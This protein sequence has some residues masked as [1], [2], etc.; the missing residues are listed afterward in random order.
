MGN[1]EHLAILRLGVTTWNRWRWA[2]P[3][4]RPDLSY[5]DLREAD[6]QEVDLG[7]VV[8]ADVDLS[9]A[10]LTNANLREADLSLAKL[11]GAKLRQAVF[12]GADLNSVDLRQTDLTGVDLCGAKLH[13]VN[14]C[15]ANLTG[16]RLVGADLRGA[17]CRQADLRQVDL[18]GADLC[19]TEL[20]DANLTGVR[21]VGAELRYTLLKGADLTAAQL[22]ETLIVDVDLSEVQG[23]AAVVHVGRSRLDHR[24]LV[25]SVGI[26]PEFLRG[27][28]IPERLIEC[29]VALH[30]AGL[31]LGDDTVSACRC[32]ET[33][34]LHDLDATEYSSEHL[35]DLCQAFDGERFEALFQCPDTG[36]L[37]S[38]RE[39]YDDSDERPPELVQIL[40]QISADEAAKKFDW[41]P[42]AAQ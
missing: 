5:A 36:R 25:R 32:E 18:F 29:L 6:L 14:L 17:L 42:E 11:A 16:T 28:G 23:L 13:G 7:G 39:Y 37:W 35:H 33:Q 12:G 20:P 8:L 24:T 21:L 40:I 19:G 26:Q 34:E 15:E 22:G 38:Y 31:T 10:D 41:T 2:H 27:C 9:G 4:I 30:D 1:R 3:A